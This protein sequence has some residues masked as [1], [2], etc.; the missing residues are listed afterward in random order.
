MDNSVYLIET[1]HLDKSNINYLKNIMGKVL[2]ET[3]V[4]A[5]ETNFSNK[6]DKIR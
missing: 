5:L 2:K 6:Y 4:L 3:Y 1:M